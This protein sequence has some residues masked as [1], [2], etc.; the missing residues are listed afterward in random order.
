MERN[1]LG[2]DEAIRY[3]MKVDDEREWWTRFLYH[4]DWRDPSLYDLVI[5][6]DHMS[7]DSA[8]E[9]VCQATKLEEFRATPEWD[10]LRN[11]LVLA[12]GLR[13]RI[14]VDRATRSSDRGVEI[15]SKEGVVTIGGKVDSLSVAE[16][17]ESVIR[18]EPGVKD[19]VIAVEF[20]RDESEIL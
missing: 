20:F 12:A 11:D 18:G 15:T 19:V 14:A 17:M 4:V 1:G 6:L 8:C 7:L 13:A 10:I 9:V 5:N 16:N 3:I 2:R